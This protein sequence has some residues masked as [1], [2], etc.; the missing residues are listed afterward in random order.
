M[1]IAEMCIIAVF[2]LLWNSFLVSLIILNKVKLAD[3]EQKVE[4]LEANLLDLINK[5][6]DNEQ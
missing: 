4:T 6:N 2:V 3:M 1:T 5:E